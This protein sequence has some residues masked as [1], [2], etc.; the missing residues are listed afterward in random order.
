MLFPIF[1]K[2]SS[3]KIFLQ[4]KFSSAK[5]FCRTEFLSQ[6]QN[7][8]NFIL[9]CFCPIVYWNLP[10]KLQHSNISC[11]IDS[12]CVEIY[13]LLW[14]ACIL[15]S[16]VNRVN[17]FTVLLNFSTLFIIRQISI[18]CLVKSINQKTH[19]WFTDASQETLT[20]VLLFY[21]LMTGIPTYFRVNLQTRY[22]L[23]VSLISLILFILQKIWLNSNTNT[24][25]WFKKLVH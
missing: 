3:N 17:N 25:N 15:I 13:P 20:C 12:M 11:S 4:T 19:C 9:T 21:F 22:I 24:H 1:G 8:V 2:N 10:R 6:S 16:R 7:Y 5:I 14:I 18:W 23:I